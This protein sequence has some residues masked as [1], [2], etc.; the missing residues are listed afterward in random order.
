M[1]TKCIS[2]LVLVA[3]LLLSG[4]NFV[5]QPD[6]QKTTPTGQTSSTLGGVEDSYTNYRIA[7][8][9][10]LNAEKHA[11]NDEYFICYQE[12]NGSLTKIVNLGFNKQPLMISGNTIY[13]ILFNGKHP[14]V[15]AIDFYGNTIASV[16]LDEFSFS[17][18]WL[19]YSDESYIYGVGGYTDHENAEFFFKVDLDLTDYYSLSAFPTEFRTVD[20]DQLAADLAQAVGCYAEE[21]FVHKASASLDAN[22]MFYELGLQISATQE[23]KTIHGNLLFT[24][25]SQDKDYINQTNPWFNRIDEGFETDDNPL[26]LNSFLQYLQK[27]GLSDVVSS[28]LSDAPYD[29]N[30]Y[31]N[32]GMKGNTYPR[33]ENM[34]IYYALIKEDSYHITDSWN[35]LPEI[36]FVVENWTYNS[37]SSITDSNN[38]D[39]IAT[40]ILYISFP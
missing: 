17:H 23:N 21:I 26:P 33:I 14:V 10:V 11:M 1:K 39:Y 24:W 15:T 40:E 36:C 22:G 35:E 30:L 12:A 29:Y 16:E 18:G 19:L 7:D 9:F 28:T 34:P 27:I 8:N 4:C 38:S 37:S 20:V 13:Y 3:I 2:L 31:W 25:H 6:S 32:G 5:N